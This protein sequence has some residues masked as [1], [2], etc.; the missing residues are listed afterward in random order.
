MSLKDEQIPIHIKKILN[1]LEP[2]TESGCWVYTGYV[3]N[4]G[5]ARMRV[6]KRTC[7]AHRLMYE[8][9]IGPIPNGLVIDHLCRVKCCV[10]PYHLEAVPQKKNVLRGNGVTSI[11]SRKTHCHAGHPFDDKNTYRL[12]LGR[13]CKTCYREAKRR[14]NNA[15]TRCSAVGAT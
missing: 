8:H 7:S 3:N 13:G 2:L 4:Y 1:K 12:K 11:N 14:S 5:Y 15:I 6:N 9:H 10:N